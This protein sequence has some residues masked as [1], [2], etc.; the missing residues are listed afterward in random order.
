M[1][2]DQID[3]TNTEK[4]LEQEKTI[5]N[6]LRTFIEVGT[7]LLIIRNEKLYREAYDTF[8]EYCDKKWDIDRSR[9]YQLM[10]SAEVVATLEMSTM[11]DILPTN[12]RQTRPLA[13]LPAD[14]QVEAWQEATKKATKGSQP[15]GGLVQKIVARIRGKTNEAKRQVK[16]SEG[17]THEDLKKDEELLKSFTSI[18]AVF[19]NEDAKAIREGVL[20]LERE[21][22]LYLAGLPKE[23]MLSIKEYV[24]GGGWKPKQAVRFV[25]RVLDNDT[26]VAELINRCLGSKPTLIDGKLYKF[27]TVDIGGFIVTCRAKRDQADLDAFIKRSSGP[28]LTPRDFKFGYGAQH[29]SS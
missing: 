22:V 13:L 5:R 9:A 14:K 28:K 20:N 15:T 10:E 29:T 11:V 12:E 8:E 19:G 23:K 6:G 18:A 27:F 17:W 7:A 2:A 21:D 16:V 25:D 26:R 3:K 24:M 1:F 4:L